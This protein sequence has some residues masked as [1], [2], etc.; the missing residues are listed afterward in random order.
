MI[1]LPPIKQKGIPRQYFAA[2][3]H[4]NGGFSFIL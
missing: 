3:D 4:L 2:L 1:T